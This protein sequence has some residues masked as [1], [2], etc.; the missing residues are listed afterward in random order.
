MSHFNRF[1]LLGLLSFLSTSALAA[2]PTHPLLVVVETGPGAGLDASAVRAAISGELGETVAAPTNA[3]AAALAGPRSRALLVALDRDQIVVTLRGRAD[4][5][6]TRAVA[7]PADRA[8]RLRVVAWLAG[9]VARDQLA[10]LT[11]PESSAP[12]AAAP[13]PEA[14]ASAP[15][16]SSPTQPPPLVPG[17]L[18]EPL[19]VSRAAA[20]PPA[21][22]LGWTFD[23]TA[24]LAFVFASP[25]QSQYAG[26]APWD[27]SSPQM[28][29][30]TI[31]LEAHRHF[32]GWFSGLALDL[33]PRTIHP[34]GVA[35][36]AGKVWPS[37]PW[38]F[39]A[40][41]GLGVEAFVDRTYYLVVE[42]PTAVPASGPSTD[43]NE[44]T[45]PAPFARASFAVTRRLSEHVDLVA[46]LGGHLTLNTR[47]DAAYLASTFGL[48]V[49]LP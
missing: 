38:L 31:A 3:P 21:G 17:R 36:L 2:E 22:A 39:E 19:A 28:W 27:S 26:P 12:F 6:I 46:R 40:S 24:G 47:S 15:P 7:A 4:E 45:K 16:P 25:F 18:V 23:A 41:G 34:F 37:G 42:N 10:T 43:H 35:A 11:L 5:E 33:G 14:E 9:N 48:R 44:T 29:E 20:P 1:A 13:P 8:A 32:G 30:P 49:R